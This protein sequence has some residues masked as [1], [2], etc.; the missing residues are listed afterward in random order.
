MSY[1][2]FFLM[3]QE[4]VIPDFDESILSPNDDEE[5]RPVHTHPLHEFKF[6]DYC[7]KN[8]LVCYLP[9][10]KAWKVENYNKNG[11][12]YHYQRTVLRPMFASYVF[13]RTLKNQLHDLFLSNSINRVLQVT[14]AKKFLEEVH[15]VRKVELA[16]F[17][18]ELE[19][20]CQI[21]EGDRFMIQSGAWDGVIGWLKKK[22]KLYEW[23]VEIEFVHECIR[24]KIDPSQYKMIR[25]E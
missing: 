23:T 2:L 14:D 3:E 6:V 24:A 17:E 7:R 16:G 5:V 15:T 11:K 10:K 13:V 8:G 19:F 9:L 25:L 22:D 4:I 12:I 1:C 21:K 20:N 18:Q